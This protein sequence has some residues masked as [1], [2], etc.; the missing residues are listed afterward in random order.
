MVA[1]MAATIVSCTEKDNEENNGGGGG[2]NLPDND[3]M[4]QVGD[5]STPLN[6]DL[7]FDD[8]GTA[9]FGG[10]YNE[11][12]VHV[13]FSGE[14]AWESLGKTFDLSAGYADEE[15]WFRYERWAETAYEFDQHNF[16]DGSVSS[17]LNHEDRSESPVFT[18]GT[19][20][21]SRTDDGLYALVIE[22]TLTDGTSVL[23]KMKASYDEQIIPLTRNS[24]I[25]DGVKYTFTTNAEKDNATSNVSWTSTGDNG[26][27]S[28]GTVYYGSNN[29]HIYL[30][31]NP[32]GDDYHF[33][34]SINVPGLELSYS[35]DDDQLT[36]TLNGESF[37][38]TPFTSGD[39]EIGAYYNDMTVI[40]IGTLS[41]GKE[42]KLYVNSP[43]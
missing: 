42:L 31:E 19:L 43:Y 3:N 38:S 25:Y 40:V 28:A 33:D 11:G 21:T 18:R 2:G 23:I 7:D 37:T 22:G 32:T 15:F 10:S 26:V 39:A 9:R 29:L 4:A 36:G 41:N 20:S 6:G 35:W 8:F 13:H 24:V 17:N 14:I 1:M 5:F 12:D 27:S 16:I 30:N 34:F